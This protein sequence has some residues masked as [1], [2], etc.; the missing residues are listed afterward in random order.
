MPGQLVITPETKI[1]ALLDAYPHLED[2]LVARVPEFKK[3]KNPILRKTVAKVATIA[4]A[5]KIGG[6]DIRELV[7]M[8][9]QHVGQATAEKPGV[10]SVQGVGPEAPTAPPDWLDPSRVRIEVDADQMLATGTHPLGMVS[11]ELHSLA[12]GEILALRSSF[13]PTPLI[14]TFESEGYRTHTV[15]E[16]PERFVTYLAKARDNAG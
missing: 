6:I 8:L 15:R 5:A 13:R 3:L 2:V 1:G 12:P 7:A 11:R 10:E 16:G 14:E 4:Q 9:R